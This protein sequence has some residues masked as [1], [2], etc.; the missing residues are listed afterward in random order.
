MSSA[1]CA[2][3]PKVGFVQALGADRVVD[4]LKED[5]ADGTHEHD[6]VIDIGGGRRLAELRQ[7]LAP[8]RTLVIVGGETGGRWLGGFDRS[9]RAAVL[10]PFVSQTLDLL[11]SNE[12]A[13]DLDALRE[14][15]ETGEVTPAIDRTFP[16]ADTAGAIRHLREGRSRG[17]VVITI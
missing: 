14:M 3:T 16:L 11:T 4:H 17:K 8:Q 13:A 2:A 12:K 6:V 10:S 5:F 9:L 15:I 7:A 1:A